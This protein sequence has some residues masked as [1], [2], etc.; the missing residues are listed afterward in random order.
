MFIMEA[1]EVYEKALKEGQREYRECILKKINPNPLVLDDILDPAV[2]EN[3]VD[4][5]QVN[6]PLQRIV[7]TKT[8][9]RVTAFTPSFRPLMDPESEFGRKWINLCADHL[10][11]TGIQNPIECYE[12]LGDFFVQ[13]GNKRVSVLKYFG[14][15]RIPAN[16]KRIMP[17][18][19]D[20]PR[21]KA[22]QEFLEFYKLT[23]MYDLRYTTPGSYPKLLS[24]IDFPKDEKWSEEDRRRFRA[25]FYYFTEA[26]AAVSGGTRMNPEDALLLWLE[27]YPFSK[28]KDFSSAELKKTITQL[29]TNLVGASVAEPVVVTEPPEEKGKIVKMLKGVDHLKVAFVHQYSWEI[30]PWTWSHDAGRQHLE[31]VFGKA[32]TTKAYFNIGSPENADEQIEKAVADGAEVVFTTATQLISACMRASVKYPKVRF[33]NCSIHQSYASLRTYYGRIHEG[34]FITGAIAG[35]VCKNDRIGYI[36]NYPIYGEAASINA[37]ALG[38]QLTNPNAKIELKWSCMAGNPTKEFLNDGVRV[39]S[40]R[41]TPV[42]KHLVNEYG[43]YMANDDG[44]MI[45]LG[46]PTWVWG[47]F[48]ENMVRS[49]M[50]GSWENEKEGQI[51]NLWWGMS[52]GVIDVALSPDLPEGVRTLAE[53][54]KAGITNGTLDPFMRKI[55]D[56]QGKVRNDGTKSFTPAELMHMDWLCENV[57]GGFPTYE[58]I[59][60]IARPMVDILGISQSRSEAGAK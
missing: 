19:D 56:Q 60:P 48:Y 54:L 25:S 34:K 8:A 58:E 24:L 39:I 30:S 51:M 12:Y 50:S 26:I 47:Q 1:T 16:V 22:Y 10:G 36:G 31:K 17:V 29:R 38:A 40:N 45:S 3:A 9:G 15:A 11:D 18:M 57:E 42:A 53:I 33:L 13:E 35:A 21:I 27:I 7:G 5:G 14:A 46:S 59:L 32:V 43:T 55:L 49:I 44:E 20:S 4:V 37:F 6:V 52:S 23:G 2:S 41:N 28:L